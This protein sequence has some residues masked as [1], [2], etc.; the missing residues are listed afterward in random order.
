M[1][2]LPSSVK[3][4]LIQKS[5]IRKIKRWDLRSL[6]AS[7]DEFRVGLSQKREPTAPS[8]S[9]A[10]ADAV[11]SEVNVRLASQHKKCLDMMHQLQSLPMHNTCRTSSSS[12]PS[13]SSGTKVIRAVNQPLSMH[14]SSLKQWTIKSHK[15]QVNK[16]NS[17]KALQNL[18]ILHADTFAITEHLLSNDKPT[19]KRFSKADQSLL[20]ATFEQIRSRHAATVENMADIM[21]DLNV[22]GNENSPRSAIDDALV[23]SFLRDRLGIQLLCDHYV[24]IGKGKP[25]GGI[26]VN[27]NFND[28]LTDAILESKSICDANFGI[29]PEVHLIEGSSSSASSSSNSDL[30]IPVTLIRP[31]VH[32]ALVELLKN[33]MTSNVQKASLLSKEGDQIPPDIFIRIHHKPSDEQLVCEVMDQGLGLDNE[34]GIKR[35]FRFAESSSQQRWDRLDEQQSYAMVR[36]PIGSLGVGLPLSKMMLQ[37][38]GGDVTLEQRHQSNEVCINGDIRIINTGCSASLLLPLRED[39]QET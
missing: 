7:A 16:E 15:N 13:R 11:L 34:E 20:A 33:G 31:W 12:S 4:S 3:T 38:F 27:C 6:A 2:K 22:F 19:L 8:S 37:M 1:N 28:V 5:S 35:A 21:I 36:A 18:E 10:V 14:E 25:G 9:A 30:P 17:L 24:G 39:I 29:V 26:S 32:H 23:E